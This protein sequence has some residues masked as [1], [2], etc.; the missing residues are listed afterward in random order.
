[1]YLKLSG[2]SLWELVFPLFLDRGNAVPT[3][4]GH[5][6]DAQLQGA[7]RRGASAA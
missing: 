7:P 4:N 5:A 1:M 3:R 2:K 6:G